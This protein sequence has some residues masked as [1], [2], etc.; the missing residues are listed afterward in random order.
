M[1]TRSE[2]AM[3]MSQKRFSMDLQTLLNSEMNDYAYTVY[4]I[5]Y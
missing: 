4:Y 3:S 2:V 1:E 5:Y